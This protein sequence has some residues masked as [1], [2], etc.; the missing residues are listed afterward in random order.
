MIHPALLNARPSVTANDFHALTHADVMVVEA[1][2]TPARSASYDEM[3]E[4]PIEGAEPWD[5]PDWPPEIKTSQDEYA[6][7]APYGRHGSDAVLWRVVDECGLVPDGC[8]W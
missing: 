8:T 5:G 3:V 7:R 1:R 6:Q 2:A 4:E